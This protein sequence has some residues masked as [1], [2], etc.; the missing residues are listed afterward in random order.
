MKKNHILL[1][2]IVILS[3]SECTKSTDP[4]PVA[5]A[6]GDPKKGSQWTFKYTSYNE[7]GV[8]TGAINRSFVADTATLNGTFTILLKET[9]SNQITLGLQKRADG[10]WWIP[11]PNP[12]ASLWF[13]NP[14]VVGDQ[15]NLI[16]ADYTV[17]V[18]KVI[19]ITSSLTVPFGSYTNAY[20]IQMTAAN[21]TLD[22]EYYF[23]A[24][25]PILIRSGT[26]D[27]KTAPAT[28]MY[29]KQRSELVT[30]TQ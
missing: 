24:T 27:P 9:V 16:N 29:E 4:A 17:D 30:Y 20:F 7:A 10:W 11:F 21:N 28:G 23:S 2:L 12:N 26:F 6:A 8:V 3:L 14:A 25:G 19:S 22:D 5:P 18:C 1:A 13:K 15:Y